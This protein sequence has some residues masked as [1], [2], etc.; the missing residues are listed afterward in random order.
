MSRG[1][2][3]EIKTLQRDKIATLMESKIDMTVSVDTFRINAQ[4]NTA[5]SKQQINLYA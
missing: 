3:T 1:A 2:K 4:T 5:I